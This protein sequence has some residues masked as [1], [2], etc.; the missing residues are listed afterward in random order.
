MTTPQL[1]SLVTRLALVSPSSLVADLLTNLETVWKDTANSLAPDNDQQRFIRVGAIVKLGDGSIGIV[2]DSEDPELLL[3]ITPNLITGQWQRIVHPLYRTAPIVILSS[4]GP[5]PKGG[6]Q[7]YSEEEMSN[8]LMT[9]LQELM[10]F[11]LVPK[12]HRKI[13]IT[14]A[15]DDEV[16]LFFLLRDPAWIVA[17]LSLWIQAYGDHT[18]TGTWLSDRMLDHL[19]RHPTNPD[20]FISKTLSRVL[21]LQGDVRIPEGWKEWLYGDISPELDASGKASQSTI[22]QILAQFNAR[23]RAELPQRYRQMRRICPDLPQID[24]LATAG[25]VRERHEGRTVDELLSHLAE[26]R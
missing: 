2:V 14:S 7:C 22:E 3:L 10:Y 26:T 23:L 9:S 6:D 5:D 17:L 25:E 15:A 18:D 21:L 12:E 11:L 8:R 13:A 19:N 20:T 16:E 4:P 24:W 1:D